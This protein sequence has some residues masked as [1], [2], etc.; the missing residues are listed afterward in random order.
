MKPGYVQKQEL[1]YVFLKRT[2][3]Q[4]RG[5]HCLEKRDHFGEEKTAWL[6]HKEE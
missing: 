1:A 5:Y 3:Q 2:T 6:W 4:R